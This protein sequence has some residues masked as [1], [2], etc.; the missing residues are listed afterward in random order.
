MLLLLA[1]QHAEAAKSAAEWKALGVQWAREA[2]YL[3]AE[4]PF[5]RACELDPKLPDACFFWARV[6]Y[7]LDRFEPSLAA[8]QKLPPDTRTVL[9]MAQAEEA[10]GRARAAE[11]HFKQA[12]DPVKYGLFLFRQGRLK[13]AE[14]VLKQDPRTAEAWW[15][16]GRVRYQLGKLGEARAALER[17]LALDPQQ[18]PAR[19]LLAKIKAR[20]P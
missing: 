11:A 2:N 8:L 10:L 9:A 20:E 6:L 16:L 13:E 14:T 4:E 12:G 17:T 5:R 1:A 18:E 3:E 15:H 19:L 7:A